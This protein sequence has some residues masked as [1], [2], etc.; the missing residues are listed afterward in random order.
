M[1]SG[2][3]EGGGTTYDSFTRADQH[4]NRV[5][6][7]QLKGRLFVLL[8]LN[9]VRVLDNRFLAV[10][11]KLLELV[12]QHTLNRLALVALG[13]RLNGIRHCRILRKRSIY[14]KC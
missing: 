8:A 3:Q 6:F 9:F 12:A 4:V 10:N 7:M 2:I 5:H 13:D 11:L 1:V 14:K